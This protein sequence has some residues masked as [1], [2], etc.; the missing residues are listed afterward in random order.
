MNAP[1]STNLGPESYPASLCRQLQRE[2]GEKP[3]FL[4]CRSAANR[5]DVSHTQAARW[6]FLLV[7]D[8][9]L[10]E[11]EKGSKATHLASSY[12]YIARDGP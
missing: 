10:I 9:L 11:V 1:P 2:A 8:V 3:F 7:A 5:V 6:L 4:A 12:R